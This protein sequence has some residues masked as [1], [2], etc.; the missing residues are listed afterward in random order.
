MSYSYPYQPVQDYPAYCNPLNAASVW[1]WNHQQTVP[2]L[3]SNLVHVNPAFYQPPTPISNPF[4]STS[5]VIVNPK[6]FPRIQNGMAAVR[7]S[8]IVSSNIA[9]DSK[10]TRVVVE[11]KPLSTLAVSKPIINHHRT[12][13][14]TNSRNKYSW[15]R[16]DELAVKPIIRSQLAI[17]PIIRSPLRSP[18]HSGK[19]KYNAAKLM[20]TTRFCST[21]IRPF[22]NSRFKVDNRLKKKFA[23]KIVRPSLPKIVQTKYR[24]IIKRSLKCNIS[25]SR[26][27][28]NRSTVNRSFTNFK[29]ALKSRSLVVRNTKKT[30]P[31]A[32]TQKK[33]EP[34]TSNRYYN[35]QTQIEETKDAETKDDEDLEMEISEKPSSIVKSR[36]PIGS[37]PSFITV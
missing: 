25:R 13:V 17:K 6:F 27:S 32:K 23:S 19:H 9:S 31:K 24:L 22:S 4:S 21:P 34:K 3:R 36:K 5:K 26:I 11:K 16:P 12:V 20:T 15:K 10:P 29:S 18:K 2:P 35:N 28:C 30:N 8:P 1:S 33:K 37:L 7:P 14:N